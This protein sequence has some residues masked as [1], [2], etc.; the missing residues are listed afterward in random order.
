MLAT[1]PKS[2]ELSHNSDAWRRFLGTGD[3]DGSVWSP[4][5]VD[6]PI[7]GAHGVHNWFWWPD[8]DHTIEST[9]SL[10]RMY[11][12]SVGRN[13]NFIVG[14]VITSEGLVPDADA[15]RLTE[16]GKEIR[17]RFGAVL[18]ETRGE[19]DTIELSVPKPGRI[20]HVVIMEEIAHGERIR[21]YD[22]EGLKSDGE[23]AKL[24]EG[25]SVGHKRIER[26]TPV[27]ARRVRLK[28]TA[29]SANPMV[30]KLAVYS[31]GA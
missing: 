25:Q 27:E 13:C 16:F 9:D 4:G 12:E 24:C 31:V 23:W 1:M 14:E 19:G 8:Q 26:F 3:P 30:R 20:D 28:V 17:R 15:R 18:A 10:V 2:T 29:A 6:V 5:M 22:V 7:R 21:R 11:Y